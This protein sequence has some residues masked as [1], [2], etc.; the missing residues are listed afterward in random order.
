MSDFEFAMRSA[1]SKTWPEC[2]LVGCM[3]HYVKA[4][5][6]RSKRSRT[7]SRFIIENPH[8]SRALKMFFR[9]CLLPPEAITTGGLAIRDFMVENNIL[10]EFSEFNRYFVTYWIKKITP[11]GFSVYGRRHRT[12]NLLES[13]NA[14][15]KRRMRRNPRFFLFLGKFFPIISFPRHIFFFFSRTSSVDAS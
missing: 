2:R 6:R 12:N 15:L 7:F 10:D 1:A 14:K 11:A 8:A 5:Q 4:L 13:F 3:F 9:L